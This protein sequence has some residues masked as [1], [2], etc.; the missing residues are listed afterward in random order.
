[1]SLMRVRGIRGAITAH[2]NTKESINE[3]TKELLLAVVR[4]NELDTEDIASI[5]FTV[6]AD[7][8]ADFPASAARDLGWTL[9]PLLCTTEIDVPGSLG[10]VI[11]VLVHV[12]TTKKQDEIKHIYLRDAVRLRLDLTSA[13]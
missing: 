4:E 12:N 2:E 6:T 3:A 5:V 7:L 1:M 11:R 9:V 13:Q 8:M 10:K